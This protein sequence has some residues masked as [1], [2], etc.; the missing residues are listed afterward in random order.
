MGKYYNGG[1]VMSF[2]FVGLYFSTGKDKRTRFKN[3][4]YD[5]EKLTE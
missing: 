5:Y 2:L 4:I 1:I 3:E